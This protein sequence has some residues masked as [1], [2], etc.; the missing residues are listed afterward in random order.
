MQLY[1]LST[2]SFTGFGWADNSYTVGGSKT[3]EFSRDISYK[4]KGQDILVKCL[5]NGHEASL[6]LPS[7]TY[8]Y[9]KWEDFKTY[10][11]KVVDNAISLSTR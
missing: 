7:D 4:V 5:L 2:F 3:T 6:P 10:Y 1:N 11:Q 8:P 9:Y